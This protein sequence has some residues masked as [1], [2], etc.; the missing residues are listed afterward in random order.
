MTDTQ[1]SANP[2]AGR[3]AP[4]HL[5]F[6]DALRGWAILMVVMIHVGQGRSTIFMITPGFSPT[7]PD[8][9][10]PPWLLAI[11]SGGGNGVTLFFVVSAFSLSLG[12]LGSH[13]PHW[14]GYGWRRFLRIAPMFY[15]AGLFY[16]SWTGLAPHDGA[17]AGISW[18]S[19]ALTAIFMHVWSPTA[20]NLVV[21]GGWSVGVEAQFYLIL[22]LL[23]ALT[24]RIRSLAW[25]TALATLGLLAA[26]AVY[27]VATRLNLANDAFRWFWPGHQLVFFPWGILAVLVLRRHGDA[28]RA[29]AAAL[30]PLLHDAAC[31]GLF[32]IMVVV[33]AA[34]AYWRPAWG[35]PMLFGP[36]A[37]LLCV[38]LALRP[39]RLLVN[40]PIA[41]LGRISFSVYLVHFV[42]LGPALTLARAILPAAISPVPGFAV[43]FALVLLFAVPIA[44]LTYRVVELPFIALGRRLSARPA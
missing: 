9:H 22:P 13:S 43:T 36:C 18:R 17:P 30:P 16:L 32:A 27:L 5:A 7:V 29:R 20:V 2:S 3:S 10:L 1:A 38:L 26:H 37:A 23:I 8:F 25:L 28:L 12:L 44:A 35:F 4:L 31:L 34:G 24:R 40:A 21:P 14:R 42:L 39:T 6:L 41:A 15:L 19:I 33:L 11:T